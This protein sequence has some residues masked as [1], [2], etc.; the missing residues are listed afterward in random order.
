VVTAWIISAPVV[1]V[2]MSTALVS[3]VLPLYE[4]SL[5]LRLLRFP[6]IVLAAFIGLYGIVWYLLLLL[7]HLSQLGSFGVPY[8]APPAP[9]RR[10]AVGG[11]LVVAPMSAR[12]TGQQAPTRG[13]RGRSPTIH[14]RRSKTDQKRHGE[15][16]DI[17]WSTNADTC[18]VGAPQAWLEAAGIKSGP[19]FRLIDRHGN[20]KD[21]R[22][23]DRA[24]A[25]ILKRHAEA[26]GLDATNYSGHSLWAGL[27]TAAA[28]G[29]ASE[30]TIM[31]QTRHR[32]LQMV[33]RYIREGDRFRD[34]A[35]AQ[36]GL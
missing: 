1:I 36:V 20:V 19:V 9:T 4:T 6:A 22:Q 29:G 28:M 16:I 15:T 31:R 30:R 14:L 26:A 3:T 33:R 25:L 17:P 24:G 7:S 12:Q 23:S 2:V 21:L 35:A 32:S 34:N 5:A 27:A 8:L 11:A 13:S 10:S 18:P